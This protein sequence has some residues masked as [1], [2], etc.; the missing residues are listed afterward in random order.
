MPDH[1][2]SHYKQSDERHSAQNHDQ[3]KV[4]ILAVLKCLDDF[5]SLSH[6]SLDATHQQGVVSGGK[7]QVSAGAR[8]AWVG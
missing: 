8:V 2:P 1:E 4:G 5:R 3:Q 6:G 7:N